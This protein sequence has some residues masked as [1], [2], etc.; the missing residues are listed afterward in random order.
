M[1]FA[2]LSF[3]S[4]F[5][6]SGVRGTDDQLVKLLQG[7]FTGQVNYFRWLFAILLV[8][9]IGYI[10]PLKGFSRWFLVLII[11]VLFIH[12]KGFFAQLEQQLGLK[13]QPQPQQ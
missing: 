13:V 10:E 5:L 6:V 4:L 1:P 8:G 9:A 3:G 12:Q 2:F 7:D 11:V